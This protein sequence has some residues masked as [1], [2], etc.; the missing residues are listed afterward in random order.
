MIS[1]T[2]VCVIAGNE[3]EEFKRQMSINM[4]KK[5]WTYVQATSQIN[6]GPININFLVAT[7]DD[8]EKLCEFRQELT[9]NFG[10]AAITSDEFC[11][12]L[13]SAG[14]S[15]N[16]ITKRKI[17]RS[18][19]YR[20]YIEKLPENFINPP[21]LYAKRVLQAIKDGLFDFEKLKIITK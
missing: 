18:Q 14:L 4:G 2:G 5:P 12:V 21:I 1:F 3:W 9:R 6:N 17:A 11:G 10:E 8:Y 19:L 13:V 16:D 15:Q 7:G 20:R